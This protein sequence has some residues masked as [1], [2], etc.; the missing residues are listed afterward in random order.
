MLATVFIKHALNK[1]VS[2]SYVGLVT[3]SRFASALQAFGYVKKV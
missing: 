3:I 1:I 2:V